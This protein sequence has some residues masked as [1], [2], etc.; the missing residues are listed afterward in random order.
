M[1]LALIVLMAQGPADVSG[2]VTKVLPIP[3]TGGLIPLKVTVQRK[4]GGILTGRLEF[5]CRES[6][7]ILCRVIKPGLAL[8]PG[9]QTFR[10]TLPAMSVGWSQ[11]AADLSVTFVADA[12]GAEPILLGIFPL[13][14]PGEDFHSMTIALVRDGPGG[15]VPKANHRLVSL[16]AVDRYS[17]T[18]PAYI[19]T[20]AA[21]LLPDDFSTAPLDYCAF[22]V[23]ALTHEGFAALAEE[24]LVAVA[25]WVQGGGSVIVVPGPRGIFKRHHVEFLKSLAGPGTSYRLGSDGAI[26][27]DPE[28]RLASPGLGRAVLAMEVPEDEPLQ[29]R[30][31]VL[32]LWAFTSMQR[33]RILSGAQWYAFPPPQGFDPANNLDPIILELMPEDLRPLSTGMLLMMMAAFVLLVGPVEYLLLGR[34]RARRFTWITFPA[35]SVGLTLLLVLLSHYSL[36]RG[37][38]KRAL[39]IVDMDEE[40][41]VL[42]WNRFE[43]IF[44]ARSHSVDHEVEAAIFHPRGLAPAFG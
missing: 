3:R 34:L 39:T 21:H 6:G 27:G 32:F 19:R 17:G 31:A 29:W 44:A 1:T 12:A 43:L 2:S 38:K 25:R 18:Q 13:L 22:D 42:R 36:S 41:K 7:R 16:L 23:V 11:V 30:Q 10:V 5:V 24:Q 28:P 35:A 26:E 20:A 33:N 8:A 15:V 14:L 9:S 37:G 40:G 4:G